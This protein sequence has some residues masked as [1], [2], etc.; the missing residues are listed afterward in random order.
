MTTQLTGWKNFNGICI[1]I[2]IRLCSHIYKSWK[3][4]QNRYQDS[5]KATELSSKS[6]LWDTG[7]FSWWVPN[8]TKYTSWIPV[9][10]TCHVVYI[11]MFR[12]SCIDAIRTYANQDWLSS[13]R[14]IPMTRQSKTP[15][16]E[17]KLLSSK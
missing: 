17:F 6:E 16:I 5:E 12:N 15:R 9:L 2:V 7:T 4:I 3:A 11:N 1:G 10:A 8:E 13:N 14:K